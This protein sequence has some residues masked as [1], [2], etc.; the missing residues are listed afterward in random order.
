MFF[1]GFSIRFGRFVRGLFS[2][3]NTPRGRRRLGGYDKNT[4]RGVVFGK[5]PR[6]DVENTNARVIA[7]FAAGS[8][9]CLCWSGS[10]YVTAVRPTTT[11]ESNR[12]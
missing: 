3:T 10:H 2:R 5:T 7:N 11:S 12:P 8:T 1:V 9:R 6:T 4:R